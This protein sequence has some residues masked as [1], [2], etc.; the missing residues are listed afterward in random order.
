MPSLDEVWSLLRTIGTVSFTSRSE[1]GTGWDGT[2]NGVV[3][4]R[5]P[6]PDVLIFDESGQWQSHRNGRTTQFTNVFRWT[7]RP[8]ILKLEHL[9]F[10]ADHPVFLFGLAPG[11][12]GFWRDVAPH[13]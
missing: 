5:L 11:E 6:S 10:G 8:S 7:R 4:L 12:D 13:L 9:R 2:G 3:E 1:A